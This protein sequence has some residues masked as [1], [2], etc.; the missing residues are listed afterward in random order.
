M[1]LVTAR[2][3]VIIKDV[4]HVERRSGLLLR[5]QIPKEDTEQFPCSVIVLCAVDTLPS[6]LVCVQ[7]SSAL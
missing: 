5:F 4:S 1:L 3:G 6:A 7:W 2:V